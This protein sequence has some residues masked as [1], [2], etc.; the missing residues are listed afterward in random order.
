[1]YCREK[2]QPSSL[3]CGHVMVWNV[4]YFTKILKTTKLCSVC[5]RQVFTTALSA[6]DGYLTIA[7]NKLITTDKHNT[8]QYHYS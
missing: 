7:E 5:L 8:V 3:P 4:T 2:H 6:Y 1:M